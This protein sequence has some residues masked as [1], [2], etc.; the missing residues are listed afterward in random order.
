M[1]T[2]VGVM[3]EDVVLSDGIEVV[4]GQVERRGNRWIEKWVMEVRMTPS[5]FRQSEELGEVDRARHPIDVFRC[6]MKM[7]QQIRFNFCRTIFRQF[8]PHGSST[9]SFLELLLNGQEKVVGFFLVDIEVAVAGDAGGP[10]PL[11]VHPGKDLLNKIPNQFGKKHKFPG[12]GFLRREGDE[13]RDATGN[14]N[15]GM[16][17]DFALRGFRVKDRKI[18]RFV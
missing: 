15:K 17:E 9:V 3:K 4:W 2:F 12:L 16:A 5:G 13:P 14:L 7:G 1:K 18:H 6:Q 11:D 10:S 8:K